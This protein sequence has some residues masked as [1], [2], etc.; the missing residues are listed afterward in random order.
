MITLRLRSRCINSCRLSRPPISGISTSKITKS[1]RSPLLIFARA[2][3][4]LPTA[5]TSKPSTS[6]SVCKYFR[7]L[8]SSSTTRTFSFTA[9]SLSSFQNQPDLTLIHWQQE[10]ESAAFLK[11]AFHPNFPAVRLY[12][13]FRDGQPQTHPGGVAIDT[14]EAFKYFLVGLRSNAASRV[15][16]AYFHAVGP[17]QPESAPFLSRLYFSNSPL[18]EMRFRPQSDCAPCGSMFQRIVQ[19]IGSGLLNF[20]IIK[21]ES[22]DRR[23]QICF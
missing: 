21:A 7:M 12:Q 15:G 1:G 6:R 13:S 11:F 18:P 9:I 5:S 2:S 23:V 3:F 10:C 4:P 14:H 17:R 20:L 19:K 22:R 8:G 16:Y